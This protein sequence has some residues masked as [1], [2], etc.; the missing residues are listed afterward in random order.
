[1]RDFLFALRSGFGFLTTIPAGISMEGI[2]RLMRSIYL[3][4]IIG[5]VIGLILGTAGYIYAQFLPIQP[6]SIL[7]II[8]TYY[9]TGLNH[10]DGLADFGDGLAAHGP[11]KE[12][13]KAMQ[14]VALGTGGIVFCVVGLL[15]FFVSLSLI[16]SLRVNAGVILFSSI[17]MAEVCAK[18]SMVTASAFGKSIHEGL[19]SLTIKNTT[20]LDFSL[21][22]LFSAFIGVLILGR[23]GILALFLSTLSALLLLRISNHN[24]GGLSGDGI[25]A[26]N[27]V[28]RITALFTIGLLGG[29]GL[30]TP[31]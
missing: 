17:L 6:T 4:P 31:W 29:E 2:Q 12:K 11:M 26:A 15:S 3:F 21:G 19:G 8:S 23:A 30:W 28:G 16:Q 24:F 25:G 22:F 27:E 13:I 10:L 1:M 18:Q 14:D 7:I 9:L 20:R 5:A